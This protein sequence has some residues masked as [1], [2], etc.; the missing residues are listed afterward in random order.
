MR[1]IITPMKE[2]E[3]EEAAALL[4]EEHDEYADEYE[5]DDDEYEDEEYEDEAAGSP[6]DPTSP[7]MNREIVRSRH[8]DT[9]K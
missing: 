6:P 3:A 5:Y 7:V 9:R 8:T 4:E 1:F 2:R